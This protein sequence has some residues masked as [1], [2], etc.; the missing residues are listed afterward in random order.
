[1]VELKISKQKAISTGKGKKSIHEMKSWDDFET[2]DE[3]KIPE[4]LIDQVIGQEKAV[5]IIKKAAKQ[6]RNILLIGEPGTGKS[7]LAMAMAELLPCEDLVDVLV[8]PNP[9]DE[10]NPK[11]VIVPAGEGKKIVHKE[12]E[13]ANL[14]SRPSRNPLFLPFFMIFSAVLLALWKPELELIALGL[15]GFGILL[16]FLSSINLRFMMLNESQSNVPKLLIDNSNRKKVPFYDGTGAH[17]GAL[18]G[19]VK[20]DPLQSGG[21]GTPPHLRVVPGLIHKAHRGVLFIDEISTL[22]KSQVDLLT[23][24]Q[25]K[26]LPI[27]GRSELSSGAMVMTD[28]VPTDFIL[29]AAGNLHDIQNMHPAL[30]SRIRGYGYE[31]YMNDKMPDNDENRKKLVQFVAQEV[32][33]DG[34]IP[35]FTREAVWE[36]IK[37]AKRKAGMRNKLTLRLRDLGGLVR[38][39]GDIAKEKKHKYVTAADVIEAKKSAMTLEQQ[40]STMYVENKKEY[41]VIITSGARIGRVNGL[42]VIG[43]SYGAGMVLPI[44]AE[45]T[46]SGKKSEV[47][48][49]GKL[50]E[51]AKEAIR[52]VSAVIMKVYGEDIKEKYDIFIQFLQT[53]EGVEGDSASVS[54]AVAVISA[55]KQIPV[56]QSVAMTGSLTIRGEVLPVGGI[57]QKIEAAID[58][59]LRRVIIPKAN[60][61]DVFLDS[62]YEGKIEIVTAE[63][64]ADV[65]RHSLIGGEEVI[66]KIEE[67]GNYATIDF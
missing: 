27:T 39:A 59:G 17:A 14:S 22:G 4:K 20:H 9:E 29:V 36:I 7:M 50:G 38:A 64:L 66:R 31:I 42:A 67:V 46:P 12:K 35:H 56:D 6:R 1:M 32:V 41:N 2:T 65:L 48:A 5:E 37:E 3:I 49:T 18:L 19:D 62:K 45:V 40:I 13:K 61:N 30:R 55:L 25:E 51:I 23:A 57:T 11:I 52:N 26:Q 28:P 8:Y 16:F 63:T 15:M 24:M 43:G 54:V 60:E 21:L 47:V 53:Y 34:K 44:E 33:K 58:A 10:N